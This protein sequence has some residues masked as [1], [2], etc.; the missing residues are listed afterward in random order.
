MKIVTGTNKHHELCPS[1][2]FVMNF[3]LFS[4]TWTS[5][6]AG[7]THSGACSVDKVLIRNAGCSIIGQ[8]RTHLSR[9]LPDQDG[10]AHERNADQRLRG[11]GTLQDPRQEWRPCTFDGRV[12]GNGTEGK[13]LSRS[14]PNMI[15]TWALARMRHRLACGWCHNGVSE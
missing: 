4:T 3:K 9:V 7:N 13:I 10:S 2:N 14:M 15:K 11:A 8:T 12:S 5:A 6:G 1:P